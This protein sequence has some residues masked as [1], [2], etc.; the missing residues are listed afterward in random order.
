MSIELR[1]LNYMLWMCSNQRKNLTINRAAKLRCEQRTTQNDLIHCTFQLFKLTLVNNNQ[2]QHTGLPPDTDVHYIRACRMSQP[3]CWIHA[4]D[5]PYDVLQ[6]VGLFCDYRMVHRVHLYGWR[7]T[8]GSISDT[9]D[10]RTS[11][12][13][14]QST[15]TWERYSN[16][17]SNNLLFWTYSRLQRPST[18]LSILSIHCNENYE[19]ICL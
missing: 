18:V 12:R 10:W 3:A 1:L 6:I 17:W 8:L 4:I 11:H 5:S 9:R 13:G 16:G 7:K 14:T 2:R 19:D 15:M